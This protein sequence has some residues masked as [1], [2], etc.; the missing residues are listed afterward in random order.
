MEESGT[1]EFLFFQLTI[2]SDSTAIGNVGHPNRLSADGFQ[3]GKFSEER[4]K[5]HLQIHIHIYIHTY[6]QIFTEQKFV[7]LRAAGSC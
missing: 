4:E 2:S 7:T 6:A 1:T 3:L 5:I